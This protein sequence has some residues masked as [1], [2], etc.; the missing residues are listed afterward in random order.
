MSPPNQQGTHCL[1]LEN[2][3]GVSISAQFIGNSNVT[4]NAASI[5][6]PKANTHADTF[7]LT[8]AVADGQRQKVGVNWDFA[9]A[10]NRQVLKPVLARRNDSGVEV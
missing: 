10:Y 6:E 5:G 2:V 8:I 1:N 3:T 4:T 9:R 7:P